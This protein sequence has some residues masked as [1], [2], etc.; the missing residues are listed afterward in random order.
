MAHFP[1]E[2]INLF[3]AGLLAGEEFVICYGVRRSMAQLDKLPQTQLRHAL[4][5]KLRL[6]VPAIFLPAAVSGVVMT[7]MAGTTPGY[8]LRGA[9]LLC[10][11]GWTLITFLGTV[12]INKSALAWNP[13]AL[14]SNWQDIVARWERLDIARC[15]MAVLSFVLLLAATTYR[16]N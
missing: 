11:F 10:L 12:P 9:G 8:L 3:F 4:I 14:P 2:T 5:L 1:I 7:M 13:E 16:T 6:L 15:W